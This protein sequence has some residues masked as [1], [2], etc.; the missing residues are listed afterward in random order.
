MDLTESNLNEIYDQ[1]SREQQRILSI[2]KEKHNFE[3][4]TQEK[5]QTKEIS[6]VNQLLLLTL[7]NRN[8]KRQMKLKGL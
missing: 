4:E 7:K 5:K 6:M 8:Y 3:D 2:M 1:F